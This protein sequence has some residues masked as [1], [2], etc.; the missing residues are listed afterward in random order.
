MTTVW[1]KYR[2][3][4]VYDHYFWHYSIHEER[5]VYYYIVKDTKDLI[6][7]DDCEEWYYPIFVVGLTILVGYLIFKR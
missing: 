3:V 5:V 1:H 2:W 7:L 4:Q 6:R